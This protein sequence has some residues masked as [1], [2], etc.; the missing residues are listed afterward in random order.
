MIL[1]NRLEFMPINNIIIDFDHTL[2]NAS[3][4]KYEWASIMEQCGVPTQIFWSTYP[5]AR[6]GEVG[7]PRYNPEKHVEL[8][9][10]YLT[11]PPTTAIQKIKGAMNR[12]RDF[13]FPDALGFLDRMVSLN[14]PLTLILHGEKNYQQEKLEGTRIKDYFTC[15]HFSDKD[16]PAMVP[17]LNFSPEQKIFWISH[18]QG[19]MA[20]VKEKYPF[21]HPII[22]RRADVPLS[23]YRNLTF[24][25]FNNFVD[26]QEYLTIIHATSYYKKEFEIRS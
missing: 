17:D 8:L 22:K 5:Q 9:N 4:I 3:Q 16:R 24:L 10:G 2:F 12:A 19:Q 7:Q 26:M 6:Y 1:L 21:I 23:Y 13:L 11:C 14:V 15:V 18:H 20:Q 25:N